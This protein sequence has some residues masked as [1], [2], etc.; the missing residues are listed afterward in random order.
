LKL[1]ARDYGD[2]K[3][4]TVHSGSVPKN[5]SV[6]A[7]L[8]DPCKPVLTDMSTGPSGTCPARAYMWCPD[9]QLRMHLSSEQTVG[10]KNN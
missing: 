1:S 8:A 3:A 4:K 5:L 6:L 9:A 10:D 7:T 2:R